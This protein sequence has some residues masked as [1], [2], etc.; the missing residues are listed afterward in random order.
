MFDD[1]QL[2]HAF[3]LAH[4]I[5]DAETDLVAMKQQRIEMEELL[6]RTEADVALEIASAL[7][8]CG[9]PLYSNDMKRKGAVDAALSADEAYR[10]RDAAIKAQ[11]LRIAQQ[12]ILIARMTR[13]YSLAKIIFERDQL[14]RRDGETRRVA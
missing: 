1:N 10:E 11:A 13:E 4:D 8:E 3:R 9:K 14:G 5:E 2:P 12:E 7:D 6:K